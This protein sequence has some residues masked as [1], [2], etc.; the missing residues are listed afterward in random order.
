M[1]VA[2]QDDASSDSGLRMWAIDITRSRKNVTVTFLFSRRLR[3]CEICYEII[4]SIK[5]A[6]LP[7]PVSRTLA[8]LFCPN[9]LKVDF[10]ESLNSLRAA[11]NVP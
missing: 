8:G 1:I 9:F 2:M 6:L 4:R 5:A 10:P 7:K 11:A 3:G